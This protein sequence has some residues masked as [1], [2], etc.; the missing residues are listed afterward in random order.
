MMHRTPVLTPPTVALSAIA[1]AILELLGGWRRR[2][3]RRFTL[4]LTP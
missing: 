3:R 2:R 4:T 1:A